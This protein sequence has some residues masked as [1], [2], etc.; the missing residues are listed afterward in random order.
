[1]SDEGKQVRRVIG[2][3]AHPYLFS[4][5]AL[6]G[7]DA[8]QAKQEWVVDRVALDRLEAVLRKRTQPGDVMVLE[9]SGNSFAVAERLFALG[10]RAVVLE[11]QAVGK[12]GKA[13]CATDKVDAVKIARV[14]LSGLAHEVW[15]PDGKA[16]ERRELFFGHRNA[17]RDSVRA[18]NRIWAF[19]NQQCLRR[20]KGLR[21]AG[22]HA[23]SEL[24]VL[25]AWTPLQQ[26]LLAEEVT[27]FQ[28][29]EVRRRRLREEIAAEVVSDPQILKMI[30]LLGIRDK[31]AFALAAFIGT[32]ERFEN[33]KKLVAY[34][35]LNPSV[36]RSGI[37][38][39]NGGLTH[40]G[41]SD[42]RALLIQAAQSIMKYGRGATH[43]WAVALKMRKGNNL[44]VAA[45][46]RKLVVSVWYLLKGFFT[47]LTELTDPLKVKMHKIACEIGKTRILKMGFASIADF[48]RKNLEI[49][50]QT[51]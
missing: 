29:A 5:A 44:A 40:Y 10:L 17:V 35:G 26:L 27:A 46:A 42:V 47:P 36:S 15:V 28:Q 11:S 9:A 49:L 37:G 31:V 12:V 34:F 48:E 21:L 39:G 3:D 23:L 8:L 24:L 33:A 32:I 22:P 41:R 18:R 20:P 38:G 6:S 51:V 2:L 30:R 45:L 43:H 13:Y 7:A 16:A 25:R 14:Y 19:L 1:M 4:A 50:I